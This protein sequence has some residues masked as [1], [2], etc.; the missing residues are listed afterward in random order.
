MSL[1][2]NP[3][4]SNLSHRV[5]VIFY[6]WTTDYT[7]EKAEDVEAEPKIY[8]SDA[9]EDGNQFKGSGIHYIQVTRNKTPGGTMH[10]DINC[11]MRGEE[12]PIQV[13]A[14]CSLY[15]NSKGV[16]FNTKDKIINNGILRFVG[17]VYSINGQYI[18]DGN[19]TLRK[20]LKISVREWSHVLHTPLRFHPQAPEANAN[21][22]QQQA[23][24]L[25]T[26]A[27]Y[28]K[29]IENLGSQLLNVYNYPLLALGFVGYVNKIN[30]DIVSNVIGGKENL[31]NFSKIT[32]HLPNIHSK[33]VNDITGNSSNQASDFFTVLSG[34]QYYAPGNDTGLIGVGGDISN[35][36][37]PLAKRPVALVPVEKMISGQSLFELIQDVVSGNGAT[38]IYTDILYVNDGGVVT[39]LPSLVIRDIPFSLKKSLKDSTQDNY[40][41]EWT[42]FDD[43]PAGIIPTENIQSL[44]L[45]QGI[46]NVSNLITFNVERSTFSKSQVQ[47]IASY[48]GT[49]VLPNSQYRFGGI[50]RQI[51]IRDIF[52]LPEKVTPKETIPAT[53]LKAD[54]STTERETSTANAVGIDWWQ[55]VSDRLLEFYGTANMYFD[56]SMTVYDDNF[57]LSV[58]N[59]LQWKMFEQGV[60]LFGHINQLDLRYQIVEN[61]TVTAST[62]IGLTR[63]CGKYKDNLIP[64]P[65]KILNS[66]YT[67]KEDNPAFKSLFDNYEAFKPTRDKKLDEAIQKG[68]DNDKDS[69]DNVA[70]TSISEKDNR[71]NSYKQRLETAKKEHSTI[72]N[73]GE[74]DFAAIEKIVNGKETESGVIGD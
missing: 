47:T 71:V 52:S 51:N 15:S 34:V 49:N 39:S 40:G 13:G 44:S 31:Q 29:A 62:I 7:S 56:G 20:T 27:D 5:A 11:N 24:I 55:S 6:P 12:L 26:V 19:G 28:Q 46:E 37:S 69:K 38:E 2:Q 45:K 50:A 63:V 57:Y 4:T 72:K 18:L 65:T 21:V 3:K 30:E 16:A 1:I 41:Y 68:A 48:Y 54:T 23:I 59:N 70:K 42:V 60:T 35:I 74:G 36:A 67:F 58:G 10:I 53:D 61:G 14:W 64:L 9:V 17:Q 43:L 66:L 33:L 73:F 22:A 32:S 25:K 8:S